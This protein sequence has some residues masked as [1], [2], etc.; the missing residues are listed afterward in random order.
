[1]LVPEQIANY[2]AAYLDRRIHRALLRMVR[3]MVEPKLNDGEASVEV[4]LAAL[5]S[6]YGRTIVRAF[7]NEEAFLQ[8]TNEII[9]R[10]RMNQYK[11]LL[12]KFQMPSVFVRYDTPLRDLLWDSIRIARASHRGRAGLSEI[13]A[14]LCLNDALVEHLKTARG[15]SPVNFLPELPDLSGAE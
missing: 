11:R 1:M 6:I 3:V 8:M 10:S 14:A 13:L 12:R 9:P 7:D 2:F 5:H 15:F 4:F